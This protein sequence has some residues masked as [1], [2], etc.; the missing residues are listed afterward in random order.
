MHLNHNC[1]A[2]IA[3]LPLSNDVSPALN[4]HRLS[5]TYAIEIRLPNPPRR[6]LQHA[7]DNTLPRYHTSAAHPIARDLA[8][9]VLVQFTAIKTKSID[10]PLCF[11]D[12]VRRMLEALIG[13]SISPRHNSI[14]YLS[15]SFYSDL[16][17][18]AR[19]PDDIVVVA[20]RNGNQS[21]SG[22][23][24]NHTSLAK[25][26]FQ[27]LISVAGP[28]LTSKTTTEAD[29]AVGENINRDKDD[30]DAVF[31]QTVMRAL[32]DL[33]TT[34]QTEKPTTGDKNEMI[35]ASLVAFWM[36]GNANL[37]II[38]QNLN[39]LWS[40]NEPSDDREWDEEIR[41]E[42]FENTDMLLCTSLFKRDQLPTEHDRNA[43][44]Q[45]IK[46]LPGCEWYT[47]EVHARWFNYHMRL[48]VDKRNAAIAREQAAQAAQAAAQAAEQAVAQATAKQI[49]LR[50][51][52]L[53]RM[54]TNLVYD[55]TFTD[56]TEWAEEFG[57]SFGEV[58]DA[59]AWVLYS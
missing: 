17:L 35:R 23:G 3:N 52:V 55:P 1:S 15:E 11:F 6:L 48:E 47:S 33:E 19:V 51:D 16:H 39:G 14:C 4:C 5:L 10:S 9:L 41:F 40:G 57:V 12:P 7:P 38:T 8:N 50:N 21:S 43:T 22:D 27:S 49:E 37:A 25:I 46:A 18:L 24:S 20:P 59:V 58:S 42:L 53:F 26:A 29:I 44:Y 32:R 54:F 30:L 28:I 36:L 13:A 31:K 34:N 45:A 56:M 2:S